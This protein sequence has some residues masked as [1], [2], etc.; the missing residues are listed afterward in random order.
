MNEKKSE[1]KLIVRI[2]GRD[3]DGLKPVER[4][5]WKIKGIS[6]M[7]A[8][9]IMKKS[10]V[11]GKKVGDLNEKELQKIEDI[12]TNPDKYGIPEWLYN[13]RKDVKT[14][15]DSHLLEAKLEIQK[16]FDV[17]RLMEIKSRRGLRHSQGLKVRGQRTKAHPRR[18]ASVGVRRKKQQPSKGSKK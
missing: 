18:G 7:F 13:R 15:E 6:F 16:K 1:T 2:V 9:A 8:N 12:I 11:S 5:I 10:G 17:R 3:V 14:G 4:A